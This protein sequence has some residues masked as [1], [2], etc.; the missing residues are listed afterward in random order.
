VATAV[1]KRPAAYPDVLATSARSGA[2]LADM[3]AAVARLLAEKR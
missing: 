2:G 3:R 1:R